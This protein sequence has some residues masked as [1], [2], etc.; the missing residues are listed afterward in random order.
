MFWCLVA[1]ITTINFCPLLPTLT[2]QNVNVFRIDWSKLWQ[3]QHQLLIV[4]HCC[5]PSIGC[6]YTLQLI[7][8][9]VCWPTKLFVKNNLFIFISCLCLHPHPGHWDQIE[10]L[11][12]WRC[13]F[14]KEKP[15]GKRAFHS[16]GPSI[17]NTHI[18]Y[19]LSHLKCNPQKTSENASPWFNVSPIY[20]STPGPLMLRKY[21]MK[22]AVEHWFGCH[23]NEL[24]Y[25]G[26]TG[27]IGIFCLIVLWSP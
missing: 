12:L 22:F 26:D 2:S 13:W 9:S 1:S 25:A 6:Q 11:L 17:W 15:T 4:F 16:C 19:Q 24:C 5:L 27:D 18:I 3:I 20:T 21:F 10:E 14:S 8:R 23:A 7:S